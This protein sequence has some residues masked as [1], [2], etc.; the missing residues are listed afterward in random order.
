MSRD[1]DQLLH[2]T[3]VV[4]VERPDPSDIVCRGRR[5]RHRRH[6][7]GAVAAVAAVVAIGVVG[8]EAWPSP[9]PQIVDQPQDTSRP[10]EHPTPE[11]DGTDA[12]DTEDATLP[13]AQPIAWPD[14]P[15]Q[16]AE[17]AEAQGVPPEVAALPL[18]E[19]LELRGGTQA[20]EGLYVTSGLSFNTAEE[21]GL[22]SPLSNGTFP[23]EYEEIL[24]LDPDTL[25]II[26]AWPTAGLSFH[27]PPTVLDEPN[28]VHVG[29]PGD[30]AESWTGVIII[31]RVTDERRGF[32]TVDDDVETDSAWQDV[33]WVTVNPPQPP[34]FAILGAVDG[35]LAAA[36]DEGTVALYDPTT[37]EVV[38]QLTRDDAVVTGLRAAGDATLVELSD[39]PADFLELT[40]SGIAV[41]DDIPPFTEPVYATAADV[42]GTPLIVSFDEGRRALWQLR[43]QEWV[44]VFDGS[45]YPLDLHR[46]GTSTWATGY[47]QRTGGVL[48]LDGERVA[49]RAF[50]RNAEDVGRGADVVAARSDGVL[51]ITR[52]LP[53][54]VP[55]EP[56]STTNEGGPDTATPADCR[57]F[58]P[59][60]LP[61]GAEPGD[62]TEVE[63]DYGQGLEWGDGD[64]RVVL[65]NNEVAWTVDGG[66]E[67]FQ[68][69]LDDGM[70]DSVSGPNG[71]TRVIVAVGE[72][73][74]ATVQV[75]FR[76]GGCDY[77]LFTTV[78]V[79][80]AAEYA[81]KF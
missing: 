71:T 70:Y 38:D 62:P 17:D 15:S 33:D 14:G 57:E 63:T 39:R 54:V 6:V 43:G 32:V 78:P 11:P 8:M 12:P 5:R 67:E 27:E 79:E 26:R 41:R 7:G 42:T 47:D 30:G 65:V 53:Y 51:W 52:D 31:D 75:R 68:A 25:T 1:L 55:P 19:R 66:Q 48:F 23:M 29:A 18:A 59:S 49:E 40:G 3:A 46:T 28:I 24:L 44:E 76:E 22:N 80:Q 50:D 56:A 20:S 64:D 2:D 60:V 37:F 34:P 35:L 10:T 4:P 81:A 77:L 61:S 74:G 36:G 69:S 13:Q 16:S 9:A 72:A 21:F 73:P 58:A 45:T